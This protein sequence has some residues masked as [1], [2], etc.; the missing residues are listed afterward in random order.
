MRIIV[1]GGSSGIGSAVSERGVSD[2]HD[3]AVIDLRESLNGRT[4]IADLSDPSEA[5]GAT[6]AA[7][8][9]LGGVDA[10]VMAAGMNSPRP[11]AELNP[12]L[13]ARIIG[14][15]LI[16]GIV[17]ATTALPALEL[18]HGRVV[19][20]GSTMSLHGAV[21]QV[22]YSA[23]KFGLRGFLQSLGHEYRGRIGISL[24]NPGP[25]RTRIFEGRDAQWIP[26]ESTMLE[27]SQLANAVFFALDQ[28]AGVSV[29]ELTLTADDAEDWP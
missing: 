3:V 4:V 28:P 1:T 25:T 23:S 10:V 27:P 12:A 5:A 15:N 17:V 18:S 16:G 8:D 13:I 6:E 14:V 21:G 7:I 2:G 19:A 20:I 24:I 26:V 22:P 9:M 11:A 29:R